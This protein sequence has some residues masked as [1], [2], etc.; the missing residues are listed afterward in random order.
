MG[1][2]ELL[3]MLS[4]AVQDVLEGVTKLNDRIGVLEVSMKENMNKLDVLE[5]S[6]KKT[7]GLLDNFRDETNK[8]PLRAE[9]AR[10]YL[11]FFSKPFNIQGLEVLCYFVSPK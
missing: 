6:A 1:D 10:K 7:K 11:D 4:N 5:T 8:R 9:L 3:L 2:G